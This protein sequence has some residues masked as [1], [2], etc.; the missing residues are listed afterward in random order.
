[1]KEI[2]DAVYKYFSRPA[3]ILLFLFSCT[4]TA[5]RHES[6]KAKR[7]TLLDKLIFLSAT[8]DSIKHSFYAQSGSGSRHSATIKLMALPS[9]LIVKW[10]IIWAGICGYVKQI[11]AIKQTTIPLK[12]W[13]ANTS[14]RKVKFDDIF[15][16]N[17]GTQH[18]PTPRIWWSIVCSL[19]LR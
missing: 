2:S 7:K 19:P 12:Y 13:D 14:G 17:V 15:R 8:L 9:L 11:G 16:T 6:R 18:S 3:G 1:M 10:N 4:S 5:I